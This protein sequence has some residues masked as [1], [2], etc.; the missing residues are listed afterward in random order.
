MSSSLLRMCGLFPS[1]PRPRRRTFLVPSHGVPAFERLE[2]RIVLTPGALLWAPP[3]DLNASKGDRFDGVAVQADGKIVAVGSVQTGPGN[4]DFLFARYT[5]DGL[6]DRSFLGTGWGT[7]DFGG[8]DWGYAVAVQSDGKI[9]VGGTANTVDLR[10][11]D[12]AILR[13]DQLGYVDQSFGSFGKVL[14]SVNL[15]ILYSLDVMSDGRIVAAGLTTNA[16]ANFHDGTVVRYLS[17]GTPDTSFSGDGIATL[18]SR[19]A[20]DVVVDSSNRPV[21][22]SVG[23][24]VSR[25]NENG[26][27]DT[28]FD[29]DGVKSITFD[30]GAQV[31]IQGLAIDSLGRILLGGNSND[32]TYSLVGVARLL[33]ADGAYD[34]FFDGNGRVSIDM[35]ASQ[36]DYFGGLSVLSNGAV[37]TAG[38][39]GTGW[40][41]SVLTP[42]GILDTGFDGDGKRFYSPVGDAFAV[43]TAVT[44]QGHFVV[45]GVSNNGD[46]EPLIAAF[47]GRHPRR[48]DLLGWANNGDWW[49]AAS[50]G[51]AFTTSLFGTWDENLGWKVIAPGD[52]NRDGRSDMAGRDAAGR[53]WVGINTG[54]GFATSI[55]STWVESAGWR[56]ERY[57]DFNGDG[58]TD[59][60]G[61]SSAGQW[62]VM[63][64]TGT[65]FGPATVWGGW[66]ASIN[67]LD[68]TAADFTG[69]GRTDIAARAPNGQWWVSQTTNATFYTSLWITWSNP[70]IWLDVR[71][72]DFNGDG[73]AD[74]ISRNTS[75][76][77]WAS[78]STGTAFTASYYGMWNPNAG[79]RDLVVGDFDGDG[80]TDVAG[81]TAGGAWWV[82]RSTGGTFTNAL[83]DAWNE[84]AGWREVRVGDFD[85]DGKDD[86]AGRTSTGQWWVARSNGTKFTNSLW[87]SWSEPAGWRTFRGEFRPT[88]S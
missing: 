87:A 46:R 58:R 75:G 44:K 51:T 37:F 13:L 47:E 79:W 38:R 73:R 9:L 61:R 59:V 19:W 5:A 23:D 12:F 62:W 4:R 35:A 68:V 88:L 33:P 74:L 7:W 77:W 78:H 82:G 43:S 48:D 42:S 85:G 30:V 69:D 66:S 56:D 18:P 17:N 3:A 49:L 31:N 27:P 63:L 83:W 76:F 6:L 26:T 24:T 22:A 86:I 10:G 70:T 60:A 34:N 67:W 55:W 65:G 71:A 64:S 39:S 54:A 50:T 1:I 72:G 40:H 8:D 32:G 28:S 21:V 84:G 57:S 2:E 20:I 11:G 25:L 81:R 45:V 53:W 36:S 14:T 29:G 41:L 52:F 15:D 16:G 80:R